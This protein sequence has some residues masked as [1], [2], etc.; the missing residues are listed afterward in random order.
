M[1]I[2]YNQLLINDKCAIRDRTKRSTDPMIYKLDTNQIWNCNQCLSTLGPRTNHMGNESSTYNGHP[3]ATSN[4]QV[5]IE[6]VLTNRNV[7]TSKCNTGNVNP[8]NVTKLQE[9]HLSS[10][11]SFLDPSSSRL[12]HPSFNYREAPID[13]FYN[14]NQNPQEGIYWDWSVNTK[15]E[16]R[17]NFKFNYDKNKLYDPTLPIEYK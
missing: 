16:A 6:S 7:P 12:T 15:N 10:C 11:G 9:Q 3:V 14:L 1:N 13:R 8:I 4:W 17:D 5:D 2:G